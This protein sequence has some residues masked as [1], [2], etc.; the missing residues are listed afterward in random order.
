MGKK[1]LLWAV[2]RLGWAGVDETGMMGEE[3]I[4]IAIGGRDERR[5]SS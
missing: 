4:N 3:E 1:S 5:T 2:T